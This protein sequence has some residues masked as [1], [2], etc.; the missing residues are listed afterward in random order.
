[1][2]C[3]AKIKSPLTGKTVTSPAYYQLTSFFPAS[4]GKSI[5][6]A[7]TTNSFKTELGFDWTK[8]Q[9][10]YNPKLNFLGEPTIQQ[11][12]AHLKLNMSPTEI[13]AA[14]QIE[15]VAS[16]GYLGKGYTNPNAFDNIINE[17]NLN[18]KYNLVD[19][20]LLSIDNKYYLSV[21][22]KTEGKVVRPVS[23]EYLAKIKFP[24]MI[25]NNVADFSNATLIELLDNLIANK[26]L[27]AFQ[28][29]ILG[30]LR[31]LLKIN[32]S[33]KVTV[34]DD[35]TVED[36]YQRSFYDPK[37]NTV[38]IGKT[39]S[40]NFNNQNFAR[41]LIHE[42]V[43]AYTISALTNPTNAQE[44]AF[45]QEME[46]YLS[47]YKSKFPKLRHHYGFKNIEE[48]VSEYLS[49]PY[50]RE[51]LQEQQS[52]AKDKGFIDRFILGIK[53]FLNSVLGLGTN[54]FEEVGKTI[55]AYFEYLENLEDMPELAGEHELRFNQPYNSAQ[56]T[57][58]SIEITKFQQYVD[59][60]V[61]SSSWKQLSQS[62]SE[63]DP[64]FASI[65]R[66]RE[67]FGNISS[68]SLGTIIN[69]SIDYLQSIEDLLGRISDDVILHEENL[70]QYSSEDAVRV[71][72]HA[73]NIADFVKDQ[74]AA[75]KQ[76]L[77]P[78]LTIYET[79]TDLDADPTKKGQF[80]EERRRQVENFDIVSKQLINKLRIIRQKSAELNDSAR[81]A[82]LSPVAS[83]LAEP[84]KL[85]ADKIKA[86]DSQLNQELNAKRVLYN[87]AV[88]NGEINKAKD[89][90][91]DIKELETFLSWVPTKQ[92]ILTLLQTGMNKDYAGANMFTV[93]L[94]VANMT[95]SPLVQ[96]VKQYIDVHLTEAETA[97]NEITNRSIELEKKIEERNKAQGIKWTSNLGNFY[98]NLTREVEMV[99][100]DANGVRKVMKQLA[101]NTKFKEAEFRNDL[102]E[103]ERNLQ[104]AKKNG[105]EAEILDAED[106]LQKFLDNYAVRP[107][108][109]EYYEAEELLT[110]EARSE[111]ERILKDI[112]EHQAVFGDSES[113]EEE[114]K[115]RADLRKEYERLGSIF[116]EDGSEKPKGT[117][118]RDIADSIIAY[119]NKRRDLEAV[120]FT[121]PEKVLQRF[122]I[123]KNSRKEAVTN[124]EKK[125]TLLVTQ[126]ADAE[127]LGEDISK[128]EVELTTVR[129]SLDKAKEDL[130]QWLEA[131]TRTEID[132]EFFEMQR[133]IAEKIKEV[134]LKYGEDPLLSE[135]YD[136]LFNSIKGYR[137]QDGVIVGSQV[138]KGLV[139]TIKSIEERIEK[140]KE[141]AEENRELSDED[142]ETLKNLFKQLSD[143]QI[144]RQSEYYYKVY[145][146]V[147]NSVR[148]DIVSD[149]ETVKALDEQ[150][151][152]M[153]DE[154]IE[155]EGLFSLEEDAL[156][157]DD[158][159][160][161]LNHPSDFGNA[162]HRIDLV[163][164][165]R[166][167]LFEAMVQRKIKETDW[168]KANHIKITK[169]YTDKKTGA[170]IVKVYERPIYIWNRT[171]PVNKN[172]IKQENP[173]FD[174]SVPRVRE[175][176][177]N[178]DY[179]FLGSA[180][181]RVTSDN[182]YTNEAYANMNPQDKALADEMV[183]LYEDIQRMLPVSQRLEGYTV[184]NRT[185]YAGEK[186][187]D[188]FTR[189]K[190][191]FASIFDGFKLMFKAGFAGEDMYEDEI[192][193]LIDLDKNA[194]LK[195][196]GRK[197]QLIKTR[198]KEPLNVNQVSHVLTNSLAEFGAYA[199]EFNG[200][201]KAMPAVFAAREAAGET[202]V[203]ANDLAM[204]DNEISRFF[205]GA[206]TSN[207]LQLFGDNPTVTAVVRATRRL[208]R[209]SQARV[210]L[211][212]FLR[213]FKN[214]F[215]NFA[216]I[217]L[218]KNR[219]G[220]TR[221]ELLA[222]WWKGLTKR[223]SLLSLEIGSK[224]YSEYALKL[225]H[226]RAVPAANPT[227]MAGLVHQQGMYK[228]LN[229]D[230][231]SAQVFGYTEMASTIPI[232]EALMGR[233]SVPIVINGQETRIKLDDAY[234]VVNGALVPK[235]GVFGLELNKVRALVEERNQ[236]IQTYLGQ[237][238]ISDIKNLTTKQEK[239]LK[240]LINSPKKSLDVMI[241]SIDKMNQAK[242]QKLKAV[243]QYLRDQIHEMYTSTQGNYFSRS[244][245]YY[246]QS[247][248]ASIL[249]SMRRWFYPQL[250]S[251]FGSKRMSLYTGN[252]E[253]G[254]YRTGGRSLVRK[255]RYLKSG[256]RMN[257]GSTEFEQEKYQRI[258]RDNLNV[259]GLHALSY[260]LISLVLSLGGGGD[261]DQFLSILSII[262][263]GTYDE[264]ISLHPVLAPVNWTYKT[265]FRKPLAK[266]GEEQG[267]IT[268]GVKHGLYSLMGPQM[269]S[270]DQVYDALFDWR[271]LTDPLEPYYEQRKDY[272]GI[273]IVNTPAPTLGLP[274]IVA[275]GMKVY[276]VEMG[277]KPIYE[278]KKRVQ[279][280][281]KINPMV[282]MQD[283]LGDYVQ[284]EKKIDQ[285]QQDMLTRDIDDL[286]KFTEGR[287][288][289]MSK[290]DV[291]KLK[292]QA[293]QWA[294]LQLD[295]MYME[296]TNSTINMYNVE[297]KVS[298]YEGQQ[299]KKSIEKML[300]NFYD[301]T[302]PKAPKDQ[303]Y[304]MQ[305]EIEKA[306]QSQRN[307][308]I[309]AESKE[310]E[311]QSPD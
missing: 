155:S 44:I 238:G 222:G 272:R 131:N 169:K 163:A 304:E 10:G 101:Y 168:Y 235:D 123:E 69:G 28:Q 310:I 214:V 135:A 109:D 264:Y 84:F 47:E 279:D 16:L 98:K 150:S 226:F 107:Y 160:P 267:T 175:R 216:K 121:I 184:P 162:Q 144:K 128:K 263:L 58:H 237:N 143:M 14:E 32:P 111:R 212:N 73:M 119:K 221:R 70:S 154:Y 53:Q 48:F 127:A 187:T 93:Y 289:E 213:L 13:R 157:L 18:P 37:S 275:M 297:R 270:F 56:A 172:Y 117:K 100:Y 261:D 17:I 239:E 5:Y 262:A 285:L 75:Y 198:Y 125:E 194:R 60:T 71:F 89:L 293:A 217:V 103:L 34:F 86:P 251:S 147:A 30:R 50:F 67:K 85:V 258:W 46:R 96:V 136:E 21:K 31:G 92:N 188:I 140:L 72:N 274:R 81:N 165:F 61:N 292:E 301:V 280:L 281:L 197:V 308:L 65:E 195:S 133:S 76:F 146:Q 161:V 64:R 199:A 12:N 104:N 40:S 278:P 54:R 220:L 248:F 298:A 134:F 266:P 23:K 139:S 20:E 191:R 112:E 190:H 90:A 204:M 196:S 203:P 284:V 9:Q 66:I 151:E 114:R 185:K 87:Q 271:N 57:P 7:I 306:Y 286:V 256:E 49:N 159:L 167:R 260:G 245:S 224:Q 122:N 52:T 25:L 110:P 305:K 77:L 236:I 91:K 145:N 242:M 249:M 295:K 1:M 307:R 94:G 88:A 19:S 170:K 141:D 105:V 205:Y 102:Q 95:G 62:L 15:E 152:K 211:F 3:F 296:Q 41:E 302:L 186:V 265:F 137:D 179:K 132:P 68:S 223:R 51:D 177:K 215:N 126:I 207:K 6:E 241:A 83:Q 210:L 142:K 138:Q 230:N 78:Q 180:R 149:P 273:S 106:K 311:N 63:I 33:L 233:T 11:I 29:E 189:P 124:L 173:N 158:D 153:A 276:G 206:E 22:P 200:L 80:L 246:E 192:S 277:L 156:T 178:Q 74:V 303:S 255:M 115:H 59:A 257:L 35:A 164:A 38:Y 130:K 43:H 282:G 118:E 294:T 24:D 291:E 8:K 231:F 2:S 209:F 283:P 42:V 268:S 228:Y 227:K 290:P 45:R 99:Y 234:E 79:S 148:T 288:D 183:T 4:Q 108:T 97:S 253:E 232:Y 182:R 309:N 254:F 171:I 244:R 218:S 181:P 247:M 299:D 113:T 202:N 225:I 208:F 55:N 82:I 26:E 120:E 36:E 116:N 269:R 193:S 129:Q 250:Q 259:I 229:A 287:W 176:Y 240:A 252:I 174:W 243:E 300:K 166:N 201:R 39:V 27:P 219:Y